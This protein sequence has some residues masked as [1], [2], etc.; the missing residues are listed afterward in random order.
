MEQN[1]GRYSDRKKY[2]I[3]MYRHGTV[4]VPAYSTAYDLLF[5]QKEKIVDGLAL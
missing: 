5:L 2:N 3:I 4:Y 1:R